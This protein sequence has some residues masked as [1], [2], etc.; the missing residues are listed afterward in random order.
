MAGDLKSLGRHWWSHGGGGAVIML[1]VIV[2]VNR[3]PQ[4]LIF[5]SALVFLALHTLVALR[6][7]YRE[8]AF[9]ATATVT[10][11]HRSQP[12]YASPF[13]PMPIN[14]LIPARIPPK[15]R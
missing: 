14:S 15:R 2:F 9:L 12:D 10:R 6:S 3:T 5:W 11:Q 7:W 1:L 4:T 8:Q 13:L